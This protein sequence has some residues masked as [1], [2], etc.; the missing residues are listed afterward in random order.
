MATLLSHGTLQL[1][2]KLFRGGDNFIFAFSLRFTLFTHT[3]YVNKVVQDISTIYIRQYRNTQNILFI[4]IHCLFAREGLDTVFCQ[5]STV[6][7]SRVR[8]R[9]R[10]YRRARSLQTSWYRVSHIPGLIQI[11]KQNREWID[12][13]WDR[14]RIGNRK[15]ERKNLSFVQYPLAIRFLSF[16]DP[17]FS[18]PFPVFSSGFP[19]QDSLSFLME[20]KI[21]EVELCKTKS[22]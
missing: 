16:C 7:G 15:Q 12:K 18:Y 20:T 3:D 5:P 6:C 11:P 17:S 14:K 22:K 8:R 2:A 13:G 21:L 19:M 4:W 9:R 10:Y 1:N